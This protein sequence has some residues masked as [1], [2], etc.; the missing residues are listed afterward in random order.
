VDVDDGAAAIQL[1]EDRREGGVAEP[2]VLVAGRASARDRGPSPSHTPGV[3]YETMAVAT[4]LWSMSAR[5]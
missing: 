2:A 5:A 4:P 3:E 1:V